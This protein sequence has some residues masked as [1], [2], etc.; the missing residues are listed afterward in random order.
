MSWS[1]DI[2]PEKLYYG[3]D[4]HS[5]QIGKSAWGYEGADYDTTVYTLI[6]IID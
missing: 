2:C 3:P 1:L 5:A 4:R 6:M